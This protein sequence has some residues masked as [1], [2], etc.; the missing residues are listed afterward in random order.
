MLLCCNILYLSFFFTCSVAN[1]GPLTPN[2]CSPSLVCGIRSFAASFRFILSSYQLSL[3]CL[4]S[5]SVSV[6]QPHTLVIYTLSSSSTQSLSVAVSFA[7]AFS[8]HSLFSSFLSLV[9]LILCSFFIHSL[10]SVSYLPPNFPRS[11][12]HLH[13]FPSIHPFLASFSYL[14]CLHLASS[15]P[16][17]NP[18]PL[19]KSPSPSIACMSLPSPFNIL[20]LPPLVTLTPYSLLHPFLS[21]SLC[22]SSLLSLPL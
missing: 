16:Q 5:P 12:L 17:C 20:K 4:F 18:L 10:T 6:L 2:L 19:T 1:A 13:I 7:L 8:S 11:L 21:G 22:F 3:L 9:I 15:A 14:I